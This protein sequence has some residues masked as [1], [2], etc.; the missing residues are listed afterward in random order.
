MGGGGDRIIPTSGIFARGRPS[1]G[2]WCLP[3]AGP[4]GKAS[5]RRRSSVSSTACVCHVFRS[6]IDNDDGDGHR[7]VFRV[8]GGGRAQ[9]TNAFD[10]GRHELDLC[11][12]RPKDFPGG[13][14][15]MKTVERGPLRRNESRRTAR[16]KDG[17]SV[18]TPATRNGSTSS[19]E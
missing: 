19:S 1:L 6:K 18:N 17:T 5:R 9:F 14:E 3:P 7:D 11:T 12:A 16:G 4:A 15:K 10:D 8:K 13:G 2:T